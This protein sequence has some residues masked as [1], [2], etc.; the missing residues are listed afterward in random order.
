MPSSTTQIQFDESSLAAPSLDRRQRTMSGSTSAAK[1]GPSA[2]PPL[3]GGDQMAKQNS[4]SSVRSD[5]MV[6]SGD[7]ASTS[8][9]TTWQP[10]KKKD[11]RTVVTTPAWAQPEPSGPPRTPTSAGSSSA[12]TR[13]PALNLYRSRSPTPAVGWQSPRPAKGSKSATQKEEEAAISAGTSGVA[14]DQAHSRFWTFTLP[15]KYRSRLQEHPFKRTKSEVDRHPGGGG[16]ADA[17][18]R[19]GEQAHSPRRDSSSDSSS[20]DSDGEPR[21]PPA[22]HETRSHNRGEE[23]LQR[24]IE[25]LKRRSTEGMG[26]VDASAGAAAGLGGQDSLVSWRKRQQA[27]AGASRSPAPETSP[28]NSS[29]GNVDTS[30]RR[31]G[32]DMPDVEAAAGNEGPSERREYEQGDEGP[33]ESDH[34]MQLTMPPKAERS[35]TRRQD[36]LP[37]WD[38]PWRPEEMHGLGAIDIGGYTFTGGDDFYPRTTSRVDRSK[39][40]YSSTSMMMARRKGRKGRSTDANGPSAGHSGRSSA[41]SAKEKGSGPRETWLR[42]KWEQWQD[43]LMRNP[44]VPLLF[45]AI[46]FS[47]TTATLA[48]AIR[49]Y[50]ILHSEGAADSVGASPVV[51]IIFAPLSLIHVASQ[52]W[53]EYF[54]RPIGLWAVKSKLSYQLIELVFISL[55][56]AELAL[57]FDNYATSSLNCVGWYSSSSSCSISN[58]S[59]LKTPSLKP[60]ICSYQAAFIGLTF[61][62]LVAY[63]SV[64]AVSLFRTVVR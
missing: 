32:A 50:M 14:P 7:V 30:S 15:P 17:A 40:K 43:F 38:S 46:N 1:A 62:T 56:S 37:G 13:D 60:T 52:V 8:A 35:F 53:L 42:D 19:D 24:R 61:T 9:V 59:P 34:Q 44:F 57:T 6:N 28:D 47:F 31:Y 29:N 54:S 25:R 21:S 39:K 49:L 51:A 27:G 3:G 16:G 45:R 22:V 26:R 12:S 11:K 33:V 2:P 58:G 48:V 4:R 63:T 20:E 18:Y 36:L 55:W 5:N 64:F 23:K 41:A 10:S